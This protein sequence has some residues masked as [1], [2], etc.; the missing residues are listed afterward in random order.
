[1]GNGITVPWII[2][3]SQWSRLFLGQRLLGFIQTFWAPTT[4]ENREGILKAIELM[5]NAKK[6]YEKEL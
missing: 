3:V 4:E 6:W 1:M 5:G 2:L